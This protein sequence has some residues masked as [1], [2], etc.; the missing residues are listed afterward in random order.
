MKPE[1]TINKRSY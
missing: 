1:E